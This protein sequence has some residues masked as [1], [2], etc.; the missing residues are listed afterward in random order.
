MSLFI[1]CWCCLCFRFDTELQLL[2]DEL[3]Q[4]RLL[5][6]RFIRERDSAIADKYSVEQTLQ[7]VGLKL[8]EF[9]LWIQPFFFFK[10]S[11]TSYPLIEF[12]RMLLYP[13]ILENNSFKL[14]SLDKNSLKSCAIQNKK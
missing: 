3:R 4:E 7:V 1:Y 6:E 2:Q 13:R 10:P 12:F 9:V 8:F 14:M 11:V 5:K